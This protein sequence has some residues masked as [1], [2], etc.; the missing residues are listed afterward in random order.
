MTCATLSAMHAY[1]DRLEVAEHAFER[2]E[3]EHQ[4]DLDLARAYAEIWLIAGGMK[5]GAEDYIFDA[6]NESFEADFD[7]EMMIPFKPNQTLGECYDNVVYHLMEA[8]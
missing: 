8:V 4:D 3:E 5:N 2:A 1:H 6:L 7:L